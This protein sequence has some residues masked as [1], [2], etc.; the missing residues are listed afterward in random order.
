MEPPLRYA[1]LTPGGLAEVCAQALL[2]ECSLR[3]EIE[4]PRAPELP[5]GFA[6]GRAGST[7]PLLLS[8]ASPLPAE[9]LRFSCLSAAL[10]LVE[11]KSFTL[12]PRAEQIAAA[13]DGERWRRALVLW[14]RHAGE[15]GAPQTFRV[16]SVRSGGRG[17]CSS[18]EIDAAVG[19][20]VGAL[21]PEW[22]VELRA[23]RLLVLCV[24]LHTTLTVGLLL[25]PFSPRAADVF[26]SEPR[27]HA[28]RGA[29]RPHTRPARAAALVRLAALSDGEKLLD[30]VGG[31]GVIAL[32]AARF[33]AVDVISLDL[34]AAACDLAEENVAGA[35]LRGRVRVMCASAYATGL[36]PGSIDVVIADLPFGLRHARLDV[37]LLLRELARVLRPGGRALLLG[38]AAAG[39]TAA[40]C[41]KAA[42]RR[43]PG[44]WAL[45]GSTPCSAGGVAC[46][47][48]MFE[49]QGEAT[50]LLPKRPPLV[51]LPSIKPVLLASVL[52]VVL[53]R[54]LWAR[55][56]K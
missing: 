20:A 3:A 51:V 4:A 55:G 54:V 13:I 18:R 33:A 41:V 8:S 5:R 9:A 21:Q 23:P 53:A 1:L 48:L 49:R 25:P 29:Q 43:Q 39:G 10:A 31:I 26:P 17:A 27:P 37:A 22:R 32:E 12:P 16:A 50:Q 52:F 36:P 47:A 24:L 40:A 30:P 11:H 35:A 15:G 42:E 28:L 45:R 56:S 38:S 14:E 19:A 6:A 44:V 46:L 2:A 34:D 7:S